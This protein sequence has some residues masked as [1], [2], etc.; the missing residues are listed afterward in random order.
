MGINITGDNNIVGDNNAVNVIHGDVYYGDERQLSPP[1]IG[2][3][4]IFFVVLIFVA[5]A[6]KFWYITLI[7][8]GVTALVFGTWLERREKQRAKVKA[9]AQK[10]ALAALAERQNSAYLQG[11][12]WGMYGNFPPPPETRP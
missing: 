7:A 2:L 4:G 12:P 6:I 9:R 1:P 5:L 8:V 10:A 11:D 3:F